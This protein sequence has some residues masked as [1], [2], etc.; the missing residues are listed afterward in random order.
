MGTGDGRLQE[1]CIGLYNSWTACVQ[2]APSRL[3]C[4]AYEYGSLMEG[5]MDVSEYMGIPEAKTYMRLLTA[6]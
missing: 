5:L 2:E 3:D 6:R 4:D 1:K